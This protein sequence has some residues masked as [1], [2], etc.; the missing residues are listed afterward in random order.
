MKK[1]GLSCLS[2]KWGQVLIFDT[3]VKR[4]DFISNKIQFCLL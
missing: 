1:K 4:P 3:R 2:T